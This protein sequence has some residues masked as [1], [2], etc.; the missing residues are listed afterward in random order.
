MRRAARLIRRFARDTRAAISVEALLVTPV[1]VWVFLAM[2]VY[3]EAFRAQN[4]HVKATDAIADMISRENTGIN[5]SYVDGMHTIFRFISDTP[6]DTA[7]RVTNVQYRESDDTY[8][9]LWSRSSNTGRA[10]VHTTATLAQH[11][12]RMPIMADSDTLLVI[13]TWRDFQ[14]Y[15]QVGLGNHTFYEFFVVRPRFLSPI[16]FYS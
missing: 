6:L 5:A 12:D 8:L 2:F 15:F 9:V 3:W 13:E 16:P 10:P 14:P 1:L 7:L 11:R 4:T